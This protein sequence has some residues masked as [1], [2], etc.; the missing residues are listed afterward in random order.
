MPG[1]IVAIATAVGESGIGVVRVSGNQALSI[2][3]KI[4]SSKKNLAQNIS[5]LIFGSVINSQTGQKIDT[6]LACYFKAPHS[7]TGEDVVEFQLHGSPLI[8][9]TTVT[10]CL[11][12]GAIPAQPGEFTQ[13]A[14]LNG[15]L[16]LSQAEAV[17]ETI[18]AKTENQ[19]HNA[20][21]I[22]NG[23]L[24]KTIQ[25]IDEI[26]STQLI[27]I[28]ATLDY[29]EEMEPFS[30]A[31]LQAGLS[32]GI[33]QIQNL[34]QTAGSGRILREGLRVAIVGKPN[35]GKSSLFN[36]LLSEDRSIVTHIAGTTRDVVHEEIVW[37]GNL[38]RLMDTAGLRKTS[39]HVEQLG[40]ERSQKEISQAHVVLHLVDHVDEIV[41]Q[42][43]N[44]IVLIN[45]I[46]QLSESDL[47]KIHEDWIPISVK[48]NLGFEKLEQAL[49]RVIQKIL[50]QQT[51]DQDFAIN[52]R[53]Q[54]S[55]LKALAHAQLALQ[56]LQNSQ[57]L[58]ML[59]IDLRA[60][61]AAL[62]QVTGESLSLDTIH[63]IFARFCVGK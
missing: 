49:T 14:F 34:L 62:R 3:Q 10:L 6:G 16:D 21:Q 48:N 23:E 5:T 2:A 7:Y 43:P 46:D 58:D 54:N 4:F 19:R 15:K 44:Q 13:R 45:K 27:K 17:I 33:S 61:V 32:D 56:G 35:V 51:Q 41:S 50:P 28:E 42:I 57:P 12:L 47:K 52:Q 8:L 38:L 40:I 29:P 36:H 20:A 26:F 53:H 25:H 24:K 39:D 60:T 37:R 55:L 63:Q 31:E 22:L 1:T 9:Q 11:Q 30:M 18:Q 59:T